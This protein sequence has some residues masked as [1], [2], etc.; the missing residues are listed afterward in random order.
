VQLDLPLDARIPA[1]Y[2]EDEELRL[3]LYRRIAGITHVEALDEMRRELIDRFG[4]D[5]QTGGV[6]EEIDNLFFQIRIKILARAPASTASGATWTT[7]CCTATRW[8][9]WIAARWSAGCACTWESST[10]RMA[11]T[12]PTKAPKSR[13]APSTC[14]ST[15]KANGNPRS[16]ARSR[17]WQL[18][19]RVRG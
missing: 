18:G 19:E 3:Q 11:S 10:R 13:A 2:I 14:P 15:T 8:R 1:T 12:F 4:K 7:W 5:A 16:C 9:T 6:P 17:S